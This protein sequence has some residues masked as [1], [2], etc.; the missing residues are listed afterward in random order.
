MAMSRRRAGGWAIS[1]SL[2]ACV[3]SP[4]LAAVPATEPVAQFQIAADV[5]VGATDN[6]ERDA[7]D[8]RSEGLASV[9]LRFSVLRESPR[10]SADMVG[11]LSYFSFLDN[12]F[13]DELVGSVRGS[14]NVHVVENFLDLVVEDVFGQTR[15]DLN[16]VSSP[17]NIEN[18]NYFSTGPN[19]SHELFAGTY[20]IGTARYA[21]MDYE[22]SA[23][24]NESQSWTLGIRREFSPSSDVS[25]NVGR[26]YIK[27][28]PAANTPDYDLESAYLRYGI[29]GARYSFNIDLGANRVNSTTRSDSGVLVGLALS[30][31][32]GVYSTIS[33]ELGRQ[34]AYAGSLL[35]TV[36]EMLPATGVGGNLTQSAEPFTSSYGRASWF[37]TGR[38]TSIALSAERRKEGYDTV[39]RNRRS[40]EASIL[41]S[42]QLGARLS[43][44][45]RYEYSR[46]KFYNAATDFDESLLGVGLGW[47]V[48]RRL[49]LD[50][51][52]EIYRFSPD[53]TAAN[54]QD[55]RIWL[56]LSY[57]DANVRNAQRRFG[58]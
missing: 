58:R 55:R 28:E 1:L 48:G 16:S 36:G 21:R 17:V 4:A 19:L 30:R 10:I 50:T 49:S 42:R 9:G 8:A 25:L 5:G 53:N 43:G 32:L 29:G 2:F 6:I 31:Q 51:S 20:V 34:Q 33:L 12:T 44:T 38:L 3:G 54:I 39:L 24:G 47:A 27:P 35:S 41:A 40:T 56:Q 7:D 15:Q 37:V 14:V 52:V 11:D 23:L 26:T 22:E 18:V 46:D 45:A 57:G 13:D